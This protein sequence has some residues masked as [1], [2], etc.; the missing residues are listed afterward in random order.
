MH[1]IVSGS[2]V[3][4]GVEFKHRKF[5][6]KMRNASATILQLLSVRTNYGKFTSAYSIAKEWNSV[7]ESVQMTR[8]TDV[9]NANAKSFKKQGA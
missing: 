2:N 1:R 5:H 6:Y 3:Y 8:A 7:P 9:F 4:P